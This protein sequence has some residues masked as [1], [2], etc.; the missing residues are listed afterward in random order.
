MKQVRR[1]SNRHIGEAQALPLRTT[2]RL[3]L[4]EATSANEKPHDMFK[5]QAAMISLDIM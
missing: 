1:L 4:Y 3:E 2:C 5:R